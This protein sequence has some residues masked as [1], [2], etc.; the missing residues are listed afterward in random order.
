MSASNP[1]AL[2]NI[3]LMI[4]LLHLFMQIRFLIC[5]N[6]LYLLLDH[7]NSSNYAFN[8]FDLL[9]NLLCVLIHR[10]PLLQ[11]MIEQLILHAVC[12]VFYNLDHYFLV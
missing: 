11:H 9:S 2:F 1:N 12:I 3:N 10:G 5:L 8:L 6:L 7:F 4:V